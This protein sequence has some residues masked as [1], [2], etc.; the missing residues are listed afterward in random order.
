VGANAFPRVGFLGL[1]GHLD[2]F[3]RVVDHQSDELLLA[4]NVPIQRTGR[5]L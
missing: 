2:S 1:L 4:D 3:H 5:Y